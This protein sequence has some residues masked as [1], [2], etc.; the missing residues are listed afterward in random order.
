[1]PSAF[2]HDRALHVPYDLDRALLHQ[3]A[4]LLPGTHDFTAFTPTETEH[5]RFERDVHAAEWR[6]GGDELRFW[7]TADAFM[8]NM[9]RVLVGTMLDVAR[10]RRGVEG[11]ASL[12]EGAPRE[13][14]G[15]TAP[16]HGLYFVRASYADST[17]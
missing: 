4:A 14:A 13:R 9:N 6:E 11:F 3:C 16:P 10:G 8:R 1:V 15:P 5:V 12:L 17:E 2:D 7:I